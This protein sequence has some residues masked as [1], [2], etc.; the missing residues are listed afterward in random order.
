MKQ[1]WHTSIGA[2]GKAHFYIDDKPSCGER[3]GIWPGAKLSELFTRPTRVTT[4]DD[5]ACRYCAEPRGVI[6]PC[7]SCRMKRDGKKRP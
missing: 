7:W 5:H 3:K 2:N 6:C 1:G 4:D